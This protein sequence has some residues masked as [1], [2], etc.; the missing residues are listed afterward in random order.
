MNIKVS[1]VQMSGFWEKERT[2]EKM[3]EKVDEACKSNPDF[4][5]LPEMWNCPYGTKYFREYG[6]VCTLGES[7][8]LRAMSD[9]AKKNKTYL[10]GGS[11]AE[12]D[13][14]KVY[15]TCFV[16]D[17]DG[18]IVAKHRKHHLFDV[19]IKG[20]MKFKESDVLSAG[21][22]LTTVDTEFGK[23]GVMICFDLR[24]GRD[25][26]EL[27]KD[28][29]IGMFIIPAAFNMTTGPRHWELLLRARAVDNQA[30]ILACAPAQDKN[31]PYQAFGHSTVIN[32]WGDIIDMAEFDEVIINREINLD[33]INEART[34]IPVNRLR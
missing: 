24:F 19:D 2:I 21:D 31:A 27:N 3:I 33:V 1:L 25:F 29:E 10:F 30:Y 34:Q 22:S 23:V 8:T 4:V 26:Y 7:V 32:P 17:R 13:G 6:E 5:V 12:L 18:N 9:V 28:G 15:N 16:F 20:G 14:D 11:I